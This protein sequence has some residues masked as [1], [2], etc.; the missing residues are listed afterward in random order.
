MYNQSIAWNVG[1]TKFLQSIHNQTTQS[2]CCKKYWYY[3]RYEV[4]T[5]VL[6]K[7]QV[8]WDVT[9]CRKVNSCTWGC[10]TIQTRHYAPPEC[11]WLI[12]LDHSDETLSSSGMSVTD[13]TWSFRRDTTLLRN[14]RDWLY[15]TIQTRHYAPPEYP[16]LIILDHSDATLRSPGIS[17]TD[18]TWSFRRDTTIPGMSVTDYTWLLRQDTTVL[19]NVREWLPVVMA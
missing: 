15:L 8:C 4:L 5:A 2:A 17:V 10:L 6:M 11:Q 9:T 13:Y 19:L 7:I 14:V 16:W 18:Y 12:I 1:N 3:V